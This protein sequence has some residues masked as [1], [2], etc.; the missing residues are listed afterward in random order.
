MTNKKQNAKQESTITSGHQKKEVP[1]K[2]DSDL[3]HYIEKGQ[4]PKKEVP[5][6]K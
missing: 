1:I 6:N 2:P 4:P 3:I 5:K